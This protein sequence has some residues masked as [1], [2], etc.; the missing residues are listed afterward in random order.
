MRFDCRVLV[1][2]LCDDGGDVVGAAA[3]EGL[4]DQ[5]LARRT[6]I[7]FTSERLGDFRRL[8]VLGQTIGAEQHDV[9]NLQVELMDLRFDGF[10]TAADR[11][12]QDVG[13]L[14]VKNVRR[15]ELA[16]VDDLLGEGVVASDLFQRAGSQQV[17][18][19]VARHE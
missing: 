16:L 1:D 12:P 13:P 9:A 2:E 17:A 14:G 7:E 19:T 11:V 3:G 18:A 15:T 5:E 4:C 6:G 8:D 10:I